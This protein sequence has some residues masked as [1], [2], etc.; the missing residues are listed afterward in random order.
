MKG[1]QPMKR[2]LLITLISLWSMG[3]LA[4][5]PQ[6]A[7]GV[8]GLACPLCAYGLEKHLG[9]IDGVSDIDTEVAQGR[10]VLTLEEDTTLDEE[11]ARAAVEKA[12]F[13]LRSF[14]LLRPEDNG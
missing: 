8:D 11:L 14:E 2:F 7:L 12:G 3:A 9:K 13:T 10:V 4:G 5:G 6:Y 1:K